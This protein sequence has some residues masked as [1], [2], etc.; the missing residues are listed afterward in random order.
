MNQA[1]Q[2]FFGGNNQTF[3]SMAAKLLACGFDMN[4]LRPYIGDDG[5]SYTTKMVGGKAVAIPFGGY[6]TLRKDEWK[7][8][9]R[10]L[11]EVTH[12]RLVGVQDLI[13][14]G[15]TT[16]LTNGMGT[17]VFQYEDVSDIEGAERN[18]GGVK[19]G[20][21][22]TPE[23]DLV[24]LPM[25]IT[26]KDFQYTARQIAASR[27]LTGGL[28]AT[29]NRKSAGKVSE[30]LEDALFSNITF[31]YGGGTV[32]SYV[33]HPSRNTVTL[34]ENW[35]DSATTGGDI[36]DDVLAMKLAKES[37]GYRGRFGIYTPTNYSVALDAD[38]KAA[39]DGTIRQRIMEVEGLEFV[40]TADRLADDNVVMVELD[41]DV[42]RMVIGMD[43]QNIQWE[44]QGGMVLDYKVM[45]IMV[46]QIRATQE[47]SSGIV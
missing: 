22:D 16:R 34:S 3:G 40:K 44:S 13:D 37:A 26:H 18:M 9:D 30:A 41:P 25:Y 20:Q 15:L 7:E 21:F 32:Y 42:V 35:D 47:G 1:H 10:Q 12:D 6:A 2:N 5:K 11:L 39:T 24:S 43:M 17:T 19:R 4:Q 28:D 29:M 33:N 31:T 8:L 14:R 23:F 46:P 27:Q 36:L 38:F 45:T